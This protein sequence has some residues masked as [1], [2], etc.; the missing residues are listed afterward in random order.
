MPLV[1]HILI[2]IILLAVQAAFGRLISLWQIQPNILTI[3]L[4]YILLTRGPRDGI[5]LGFALG[6]VQDLVTTQ[7]IGISSLSYAITCFI[8]GKLS[9]LWSSSS[10]WAWIGWL[11]GGTILYNLIYFYFYATGT[12]LSFGKLLWIYAIPS[13]LF[14]SVI[15]ALWSLTP[16]WKLSTRR[17]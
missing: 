13:A 7:F 1:R 2:V 3:Y 12:Y 8:I 15:G 17:G 10:R 6:I 5:W 14:T 16:W 9:M 4:F 11:L